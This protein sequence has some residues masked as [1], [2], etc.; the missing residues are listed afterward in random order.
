MAVN[1]AMEVRA[2][3]ALLA[4]L[5]AIGTPSTSWLTKPTVA[6]GIPPDEVEAST[7]PRIYLQ[8]VR[9]EYLDGEQ[10]GTVHRHRAVFQ[11]FLLAVADATGPRNVLNLK[12]DVLRAVFAAEGAITTQFATPALP[13]SFEYRDDYRDAGIDAGVQELALDLEINH[14]DP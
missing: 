1:Q 7:C 3:V 8:H 12:A 6:E 14:T 5:A 10:F 9:T 4:A 2:T 13:L 11:A